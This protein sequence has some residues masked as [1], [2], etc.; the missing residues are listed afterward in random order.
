MSQSCCTHTR[1]RRRC[2]SFETHSSE[3]EWS[4]YLWHDSFIRATRLIHLNANDATQ[5]SEREW[6]PYLWHDSFIRATRLIH[7]NAHDATQSSEREWSPYS[8]HDSIIRATWLIHRM[9]CQMNESLCTYEWVL[10]QIW[11]S[12]T[13]RWMG[14]SFAFKW[15]SHVAHTNESCHK[16]GHHSHS[17]EW[18]MSH[19]RMS[20]VTNMDIIHIQM[21]E[22]C[23]TYEWVVSQIWT[24]F[25]FR[26]MSH[27]AHTN[28]SCHKYGHHSH[29]D[30]WV[31]SFIHD[32]NSFAMCRCT[33]F[34]FIRNSSIFV[35]RLIHM[36][37]MTHS[38]ECD[39]TH[40][41]VGAH[42]L[43]SFAIH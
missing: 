16:Y 4:P 6:P 25:T 36:C 9:K 43:H 31:T 11:R 23:R 15:M 14:H 1:W 20:R 28:E 26:W 3:N 7:L 17:D 24:S 2:T 34:A 38:S 21:N 10:S 13:F 19:I 39:V 8:W 22:S 33:S 37:D 41:S 35:T 27:V 42:H 32:A 12:F 18:V 29:S 5:S 40:S 30:E